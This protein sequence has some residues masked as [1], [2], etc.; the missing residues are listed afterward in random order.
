MGYRDQK[1][2]VSSCA[3]SAHGV[4]VQSADTWAAGGGQAAQSSMNG[5]QRTETRVNRTLTVV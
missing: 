2:A 5:T 4:Q 3:G 1:S